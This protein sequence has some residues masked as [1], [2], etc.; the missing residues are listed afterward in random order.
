MKVIGPMDI[1][2][3]SY[4]VLGQFDDEETAGNALSYMKTR[5]VRFLM[6]QSMSGYGLSKQVLGFVPMQDFSRCWTDKDLYEKYK[7]TDEEIELIESMIRS[8]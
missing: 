7:I 6:L 8:I 4:F 1:C 5:F 3:H 2:T